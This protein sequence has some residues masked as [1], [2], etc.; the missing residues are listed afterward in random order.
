MSETERKHRGPGKEHP[1]PER[2][3]TPMAASLAEARDRLNAAWDAIKDK[4]AYS[5]VKFADLCY[6]VHQVQNHLTSVQAL[7]EQFERRVQ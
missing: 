7:I 5:G 3:T 6:H 4:P 1:D 2:P